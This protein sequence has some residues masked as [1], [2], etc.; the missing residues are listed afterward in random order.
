[1][2]ANGGYM[3]KLCL[4][5]VG[6]AISGS[7]LAALPAPTPEQAAKAEEAKAKAAWGTKVSNYQLCL[8]QDKVANRYLKEKSKPK[9]AHNLAACENPGPFAPPQVAASK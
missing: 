4:M 2:N 9:P 5:I 7:A 1:M 8:S 3:R 6:I